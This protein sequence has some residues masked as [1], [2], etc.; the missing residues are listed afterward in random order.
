MEAKGVPA[1]C[2]HALRRLRA[3]H[4]CPRGLRMFDLHSLRRRF[5]ALQAR[6]DGRV[7]VFF[8]GPDGKQVPQRVID[9]MVH[10]LTACNANHGGV[11]ATSR[12]S[13]R[14]LADAHAAIADLL[15]A[16]SPD[17]VVFGANMTTL[18]LHLSRTIS[19]RLKPGDEVMVT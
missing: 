3:C 10:Y 2:E 8:D 4:P 15:N 9:A 12:E 6:P 13:D 5:P 18:T 7:P 1:M 17:E 16:P 11:F 19:K 14:I